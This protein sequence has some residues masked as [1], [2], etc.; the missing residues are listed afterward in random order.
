MT[1]NT[2]SLDTLITGARIVDGTGNPWFYGDVAIAGDRIAAV[3]PPERINRAAVGEVV[4]ATGLVVCPGFIDIQS[5][6]I[7]PFLTD[8]RSLSKVTQGVTTE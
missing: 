1:P 4:D 2:P 7:V 5:H 6:S 8:R 3:T